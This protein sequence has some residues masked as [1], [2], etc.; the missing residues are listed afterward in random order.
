MSQE[1]EQDHAQKNEDSDGSDVNPDLS[2][3]SD[4]GGSESE[5]EEID[6]TENPV[7]QVLSAFLE[8]E[9]GKNICDI[10]QDIRCSLDKNTAML[11]KLHSQR[12]GSSSSSSSSSSSKKK[13]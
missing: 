7:F 12:N 8:T 11:K 9:D 1:K 5:Y 4:G 10:L 13:K 3:Y 2:D 6:V